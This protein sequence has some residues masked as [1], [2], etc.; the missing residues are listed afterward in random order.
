MNIAKHKAAANGA[1]RQFSPE[2]EPS[3]A[4]ASGSIHAHAL[5]EVTKRLHEQRAVNS[6][7]R[8]AFALVASGHL[9]AVRE[10]LG[11]LLKEAEKGN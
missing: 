10:E 8:S 6:F 2:R 5:D 7:L 3:G 11:V 9:S 4:P 1:H